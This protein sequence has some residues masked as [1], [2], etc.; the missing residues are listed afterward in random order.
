MGSI[1]Q[2]EN[3]GMACLR[4][5]ISHPTLRKWLLRYKA[6]GNAGLESRSHR[7]QK[8]PNTKVS[9]IHEQWILK[10][11]KAQLGARRIQSELI[12]RHN[13]HLSLATIHKV[14]KRN[15]VLPLRKISRKNHLKRYER[16]IPG[17]RV[18]MDTM[19]I[20]PGLYQYTA[21]DDCSRFLVAGVYPRPT[22]ANILH[23]LEK[24]MEEMSFPVQRIQ[25]DRGREFF[26]YK[27]QEKLMDWAIKFRPVKPRWPHLNGKVERVQK[28][29]LYEFYAMAD[30]HDPELQDRL[31]EWVFHYNWMRGH[32]SLGGKAPIDCVVERSSKTPITDEVKSL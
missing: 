3:A 27:V 18:Q 14:L 20:Q 32:G 22:T 1:A 11:R 24:V 23:F 2:T 9:K 7:H 30:L 15:K 17:D 29:M 6:E 25:T 16:A 31:D 19:K 5:G 12:W 13:F 26:A 4:C 8:S 28:T 21:E 10:Y